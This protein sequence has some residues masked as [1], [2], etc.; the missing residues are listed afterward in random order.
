MSGTKNCVH[1]FIKC[2]H[3]IR[4]NVPGQ[5]GCLENICR[6][7]TALTYIIDYITMR[8]QMK[9]ISRIMKF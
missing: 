3:I 7:V 5:Q 6:N 4:Y 1:I 9:T 2:T 8:S